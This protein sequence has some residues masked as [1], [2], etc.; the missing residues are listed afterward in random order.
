MPVPGALLSTT[1]CVAPPPNPPFRFLV[2]CP[3]VDRS[4][5]FSHRS[6]SGGGVTPGMTPAGTR[7]V[8]TF[9]GFFSAPSAARLSVIMLRST[10]DEIGGGGGGADSRVKVT[11]E[12]S[13]SSACKNPELMK[14]RCL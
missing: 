1:P 8:R 4:L 5:F 3:K 7:L 11:E 13:A 12:G 10:R 9:F 6:G 2:P 14:S